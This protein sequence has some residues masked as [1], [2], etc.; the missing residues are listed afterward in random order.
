[1]TPQQEYPVMVAEYPDINNPSISGRLLAIIMM[2]SCSR[3]HCSYRE[4]YST[5]SALGF[6]RCS[7]VSYRG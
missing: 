7:N 4:V 3:N 1:M 5:T 6:G 2:I